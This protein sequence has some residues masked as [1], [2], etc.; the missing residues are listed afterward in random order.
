MA[1]FLTVWAGGHFQRS[2]YFSVQCT[3]GQSVAAVQ[4]L[5]PSCLEDSP[6]SQRMLRLV[7]VSPEVLSV[8]SYWLLNSALNDGFAGGDRHFGGK[9]N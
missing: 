7:L 4:Y 5:V 3:R 6:S 9:S 8:F 1:Q 2:F